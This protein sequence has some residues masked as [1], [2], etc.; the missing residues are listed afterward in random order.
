MS[1]PFPHHE[2]LVL[3]PFSPAP[4]MFPDILGVWKALRCFAEEGENTK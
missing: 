1:Q 4:M 3:E 2:G